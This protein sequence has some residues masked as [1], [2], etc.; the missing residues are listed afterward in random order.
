MILHMAGAGL[1][2]PSPVKNL[3]GLLHSTEQLEHSVNIVRLLRFVP[4]K[5]F[6]QVSLT[7]LA[8]S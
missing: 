5:T 1:E 2:V 3:S 8:F 6:Y 4:G 7:F